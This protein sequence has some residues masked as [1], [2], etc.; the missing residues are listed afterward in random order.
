MDVREEGEYD[1]RSLESPSPRRSPRSPAKRKAS[2]DGEML[3]EVGHEAKSIKRDGVLSWEF[4]EEEEAQMCKT[5]DITLTV[6][7]KDVSKCAE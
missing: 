1:E 3:M 7:N 5:G 2:E 4:H 6:A